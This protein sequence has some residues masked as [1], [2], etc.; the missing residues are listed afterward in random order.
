MPTVLFTTLYDKDTEE[1]TGEISF[2][3]AMKASGV[4]MTAGQKWTRKPHLFD[5]KGNPL[6]PDVNIRGGTIGRIAFTVE[7][8]GFYIPG[9]GIAGL[10]MS[11]EAAQIIELAETSGWNFKDLGFVEEDGYDV[12]KSLDV[13]CRCCPHVGV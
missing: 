10:R 13:R 3:F 12:T 8:G 7:E 2:K 11:L 5:A 4:N 1:P 9:I 6:P